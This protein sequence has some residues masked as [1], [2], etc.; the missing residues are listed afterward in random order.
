[1]VEREDGMIYLYVPNDMHWSNHGAMDWEDLRSTS[2][3]QTTEAV[4]REYPMIPISRP[5][6]N[7]DSAEGQIEWVMI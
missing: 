1:M 7:P 6:E 3:I 5:P 2:T 4:F